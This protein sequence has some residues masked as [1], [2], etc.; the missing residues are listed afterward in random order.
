MKMGIVVTKFREERDR[1]QLIIEVHKS[2]IIVVMNYWMNER[3]IYNC[4]TIAYGNIVF[5]ANIY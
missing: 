3:Y 1:F 5:G 2:S 4:E